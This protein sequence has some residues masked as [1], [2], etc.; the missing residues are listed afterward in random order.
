VGSVHEQTGGCWRSF[1]TVGKD[2]FEHA[3]RLADRGGG[4]AFG[5]EDRLGAGAGH[6]VVKIHGGG[7]SIVVVVPAR[8]SGKRTIDD[9]RARG[10]EKTL[11]VE[12]EYDR[13]G[14]GLDSDYSAIIC[15]CDAVGVLLRVHTGTG[16]QNRSLHEFQAPVTFAL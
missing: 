1:L 14:R 16:H 12:R 9:D 11:G 5:S 7:A 6:R 8:A 3:L 4:N 15:E 2:A 13:L 10:G